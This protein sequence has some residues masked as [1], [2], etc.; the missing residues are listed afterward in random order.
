VRPTRAKVLA[1]AVEILLAAGDL[2]HARAA[3]AELSEIAGVFDASLLSATSAHATGSVLLSEGDM[4]GASTALRRASE[5]WRT[6]EMPYEQAQ[7]S[8]LL[9]AI[10]ERRGDDVG[11]RLEVDAARRLFKELNAESSLARL[12]KPSS[13][14]QH[15]SVGPLSERELQVL[16][17]LATGKSNRQIAAELFISEKAVARHVSNIFDKLGVSSRAAATACAYQHRLI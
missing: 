1:P 15:Q 14:A 17:V 6:L 4:A 7:S 10:C 11:H 16:R 12:A 8:L 9:A 5:L 2:E 3:A 13:H